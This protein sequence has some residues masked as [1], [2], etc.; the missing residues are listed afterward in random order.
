MSVPR[1]AVIGTGWW[2]T[3]AH[4]P[5]L[6]DYD[7]AELVAVC[8]A[9][10]DRARVV[11]ERFGVRHSFNDVSALVAAGLVDG[12][13]VATPHTSHHEVARAALDAGL[14]VLVEK[15]LTTSASDAWE[16]VAVAESAGLHLAAGYTY[17]HTRTA[18]FVQRAV[19]EEIGELVCVAAEFASGTVTL[20]AGTEDPSTATEPHPL[21]YSDPANAGGG[22][23][24]AQVTHLM[25]MV[26]WATG[27]QVEEVSCYLDHRGLA[28]DVAD[29]M[30][31]RFVGGGLGT[32]TSTGTAVGGQPP[33]QRI[34]YYG[35]NGSLEQD[36]L[37]ARATLYRGDGTSISSEPAVGEPA[38]PTYAPARCF[39]DLLSGRGPNLAPGR[40]AAATTAFLD[41]AYRSAASG[42]PQ[43]VH[44]RM[45]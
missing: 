39:A 13:I 18:G 22:Q 26:L 45:G 7:G 3:T 40:P 31:F 17:Q 1:L 28:V 32:V 43:R 37:S 44:A 21:T 25:G 36:L 11:A 12:V 15:P 29:A 24:H 19:R 8:D 41:A 14:H 27:R 10:A 30:A 38:Y 16:L 23:G 34:R 35:T 20:F 5:S 6:V 9:R 33:H 4:L 2:A 42:A